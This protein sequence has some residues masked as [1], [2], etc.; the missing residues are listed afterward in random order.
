MLYGASEHLVAKLQN[1]RNGAAR[2]VVR[3]GKHEHISPVLKE[4]YWLPVELRIVYRI[5]VLTF[6]CVHGLGHKYLQEL[7][8]GLQV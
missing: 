7:L 4:L 3:L 6:K 5:Y 1:V 2:I 8:D